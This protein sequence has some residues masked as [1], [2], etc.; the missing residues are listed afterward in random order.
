M[1]LRI[2]FKPGKSQSLQAAHYFNGAAVNLV[3]DRV[4]RCEERLF[5]MDTGEGATIQLRIWSDVEFGGAELHH[6]F[7]WLAIVREDMDR[8]G[9]GPV[10][11]D[12]VRRMVANWLAVRH[13]GRD[14]YMEESVLEHGGVAEERTLIS[15]YVEKGRT[16]MLSGEGL[17]FTRLMDRTYGLTI[18]GHGSYLVEAVQGV[19]ENG[20]R[21]A[22]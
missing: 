18:G 10:D 19:E 20:L 17:M 3:E 16:E 8:L 12:M 22:S 9:T 7:V 4:S 15:L 13:G 2:T 21:R 6:L 1:S 5:V 11:P 14:L